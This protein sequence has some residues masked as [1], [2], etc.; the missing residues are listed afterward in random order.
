M[1]K[2]YFRPINIENKDEQNFVKQFLADTKKIGGMKLDDHE[3]DSYRAAIGKRR[4]ISPDFSVF[5][6][7]DQKIIGLVDA[8]PQ[9][10]NPKV[11]FIT[12]IYLLPEFRGQGLGVKLE[13]YALDVF[14]KY[15]CSHFELNVFFRM[16]KER[17]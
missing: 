17:V 13:T 15:K 6:L 8:Y 5:A 7:L 12:F 4:E 11:G 10:N 14:T 9:K 3:F 2:I 1:K 16:R